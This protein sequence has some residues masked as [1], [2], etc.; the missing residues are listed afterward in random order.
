MLYL[1]ADDSNAFISGK[2]LSVTFEMANSVCSDLSQWFICNLLSVNY[3]KTAYMLFYPNAND[4]AL[5][6]TD[7]LSIVMDDNLINRANSVKFLGIHIDEKL[8][9]KNHV[10]S[11][12]SKLNSVRGMLYSRRD[13]LPNSCRRNL[14]FALV[15]PHLQYGIEVYSQ[16]NAYI[17]EPLHI[18]CNRVLRTLQNADRYSN[19]KHLY[20]FYDTLPVSLLGKLRLSKL[21]Y[22]SLYCQD[23]VPCST[24]HLLKL[25]QSYHGYHTRISA[26]NYLY[27]QSN[28]AFYSSFVN[29]C[30]TL[31]NNIPDSIRNCSSIYIFCTM[32][33]KYLLDNL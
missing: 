22:K 30:C 33:K 13:F 9:F 20:C 25:N 12:I 10:N 8:N 15:Y 23:S 7:K 17:I 24:S 27:K 1:F 18:A 31:W 2:S 16:T 19:V 4:I 3:E 6:N 21:I 32:Y 29:A 26:T 11:V 5:I 28:S 14:Y